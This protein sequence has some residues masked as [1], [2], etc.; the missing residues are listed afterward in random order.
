MLGPCF[1]GDIGM[2][3]GRN[4]NPRQKAA[5]LILISGPFHVSKPTIV[6]VDVRV[7]SRAIDVVHHI[8]HLVGE[9]RVR[10]FCV[11]GHEARLCRFVASLREHL[12]VEI[13]YS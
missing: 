6:I 5:W 7:P 13:I 9:R 3:H 4:G 11:P 12:F 8:C 10:D 1:F 2:L